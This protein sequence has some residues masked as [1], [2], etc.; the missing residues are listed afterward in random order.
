MIYK[1]LARWIPRQ[2][3]FTVFLPALL[4]GDIFEAHAVPPATQRVYQPTRAQ[5]RIEEENRKRDA[6]VQAIRRQNA[7]KQGQPAPAEPAVPPSAKIR[8]AWINS[9]RFVLLQDVA[10][11]YNMKIS[12]QKDGITLTGTDSI[13]FFYDKRMSVVNGITLYLTHAPVPRGALVYLDEK[14]FL[15]VIDP[16]VRDAPLWRHPLGTI[17]IDPGH[18]GRDNGAPGSKTILEKN[19]NLMIAAKLATRLRSMGY[20]VIMTRTD[21]RF[22]SL[23]QRAEFCEKMKPDLYISIHCNATEKNRTI[24]GIETFAMT[25]QDTAS[26]NETR[27]GSSSGPGNSFDKNNYRLAYEVQ[28]S[29]I[30]VTRTEDRGVKH[31]RFF[32]LRNATCPAILVETGFISHP[33]EG[34]LLA[35]SAYQ[36][37]IVTGIVSGISSYAKSLRPPETSKKRR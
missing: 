13:R 11:F 18:G 23:Q 25:P 3:L 12:Y 20:R 31:A 22:I 35:R 16:V 34:A 27:R 28:K 29:L 1:I 14:D 9:R 30:A 10:R 37:K 7:A 24:R 2:R 17:M 19:V 6:R 26:T 4:W 36:D 32:V 33:A 21:D 8:Y 5:Q 15:L